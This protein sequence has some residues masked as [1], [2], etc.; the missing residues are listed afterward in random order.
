MRKFIYGL[1]FLGLVLIDQILK[2]IFSNINTN[3]GIFSLTTVHN[4]GISFGLFQGTNLIIILVSII[5]LGI[6]WH[7]REEFKG[8]EIFL[9]LIT[10]G[11]IG[12]LIDRI[13]RG[14]VLDYIN[15]HFWP[16]FN[17]ADTFL[18]IGVIGYITT[19][20][21]EKSKTHQDH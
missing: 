11:I 9:T 19:K 14:Y 8:H 1:I 17:A 18:F 7:I 13:I 2:I 3:I 16:V 20:I 6:L 5:F 21:L 12:N 10:A 15:F 4:T